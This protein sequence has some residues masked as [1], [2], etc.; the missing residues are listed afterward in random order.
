MGR[1]VVVQELEVVVTAAIIV[2][3][4]PSSFIENDGV[5]CLL[6]VCSENSILVTG[7]D[8]NFRFPFLKLKPLYLDRYN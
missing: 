8:G 5:S 4:R 2:V 7:M 1:R 3:R 6:Q